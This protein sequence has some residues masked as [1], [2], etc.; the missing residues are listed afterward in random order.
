MMNYNLFLLLLALSAASGL[1]L[2]RF[3]LPTNNPGSRGLAYSV[4]RS[5]S[6]LIPLAT[7]RAGK[8]PEALV[9]SQSQLKAG[10][11]ASAKDRL[12][13]VL[14]GVGAGMVVGLCLSGLEFGSGSGGQSGMI[15]GITSGGL[16][17]LNNLLGKRV[18]VMTLPEAEKRLV[19]DFSSG[20]ESGLT[21]RGD[22]A[23]DSETKGDRC[24]VC[25]DGD[26]VIGCVDFQ[27]RTSRGVLPDHVHV[28]NMMVS[29]DYR[30]RGIG[31]RLMEE[32]QAF[33]KSNYE[34]VE[35]VSLEVDD[36][37]AKAIALYQKSGFDNMESIGRIGSKN[38]YGTFVLGR[39]IMYKSL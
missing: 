20:V 39:S 34:T 25:R 8:S 7:F 36:D 24:I 6:E 23:A 10:Y 5:K 1:Q 3:T 4:V 12:K 2:P 29:E 9:A 27:F 30:R 28:K 22:D 26:D 15:V 31:T 16:I 14:E 19:Q 11:E 18:Y 33:V 38:K 32:L 17:G 35:A 13:S 21:L 37:N